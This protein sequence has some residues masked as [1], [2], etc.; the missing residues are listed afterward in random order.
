MQKFISNIL[1]II[2][3]ISCSITA[4]TTDSSRNPDVKQDY[5]TASKHIVPDSIAQF[6]ILACVSDLKKQK[7]LSNIQFRNSRV[8]NKVSGIEKKQYILCGEFKADPEQVWISFATIKT[9]G[10][11]QW[12]GAQS[13]AFCQDSTV[14][15]NESDLSKELSEKLTSLKN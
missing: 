1:I 5:Y 6:L 3:L 13:S 15:W 8:G 4:K 11:E 7:H 2:L 12:Q 9:V 14:V 10:Y